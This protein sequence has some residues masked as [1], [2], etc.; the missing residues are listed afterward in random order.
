MFSLSQAIG[1]LSI[2]IVLIIACVVILWI[3][4]G[5]KLL[6]ADYGWLVFCIFNCYAGGYCT[7]P[8]AMA[9]IRIPPKTATAILTGIPHFAE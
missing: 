1:L 8:I 6:K 3:L 7:R 4:W 9:I 2:H 5:D